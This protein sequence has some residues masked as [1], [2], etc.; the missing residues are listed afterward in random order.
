MLMHAPV[1]VDRQRGSRH[2]RCRRHR[3]WTR[4]CQSRVTVTGDADARSPVA[5]DASADPVTV[6]ADSAEPVT[7]D[8]D[9]PPVTADAVRAVRDR[10][11]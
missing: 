9:A 2:R 11:C 5:V 3:R 1:T 8:A 10:R 6:E 4:R 7:V